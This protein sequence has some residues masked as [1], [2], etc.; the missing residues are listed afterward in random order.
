LTTSSL[1]KKAAPTTSATYKRFANAATVVK[2]IASILGLT[3]GFVRQLF[4]LRSDRRVKPALVMHWTELDAAAGGD[5][6]FP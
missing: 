2:A 4:E 1:W 5:R 6:L 3:D